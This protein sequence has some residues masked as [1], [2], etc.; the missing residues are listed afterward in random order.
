MFV[1]CM[2]YICKGKLMNVLAPCIDV[3]KNGNKILN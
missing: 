3:L 2:L 1:Y